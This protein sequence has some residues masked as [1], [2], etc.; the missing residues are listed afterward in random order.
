MSLVLWR[1]IIWSRLTPRVTA[2]LIGHSH[3]AGFRRW[4]VSIRRGSADLA[5]PRSI[6]MMPL[7]MKMPVPTISPKLT[8]PR[9]VPRP[10]NVSSSAAGA[11]GNPP[12][13]DVVA[14]GPRRFPCPPSVL[15]ARAARYIGAQHGQAAVPRSGSVVQP[16][17]L[18]GMDPVAACPPD[19]PPARLT[20]RP[21]MRHREHCHSVAGGYCHVRLT[22]PPAAG[23]SARC[24][25]PCGS[26][27]ASYPPRLS[28]CSGL[29]GQARLAQS[30]SFGP[31][32]LH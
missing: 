1:A 4:P 6:L 27:R 12:P 32:R 9:S 26:K 10:D 7:S 28:Y 17:G 14:D 18:S 19:P 15:P 16:R 31:D 29:T 8:I 25:A 30:T 13:I 20:A 3:I 24:T 5:R 11:D 21:P 22:L 23:L 2:C